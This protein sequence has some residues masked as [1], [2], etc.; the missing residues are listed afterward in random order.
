MR[1]MSILR[2]LRGM[3]PALSQPS[4]KHVTSFPRLGRTLA[5]QTQAP[6]RCI[7]NSS[8]RQII[9]PFSLAQRVSTL[10]SL[11][12]TLPLRAPHRTFTSSTRFQYPR[13]QR[14][15]NRFDGSSGAGSFFSTLIQKSKPQHF[16]VIGLGISGIYLYNTDVVEMTGRRRFNVVSH[17]QELKMGAETYREILATE[18]GK[19]LPEDHPLTRMVDRVLQRLI[20][21]APIPGANWKVHVINDPDQANAF[22]IPGGKVFV[23]TGILPI[24]QDDDGLAA[25]L[26]HE[27]A[28]VVARHPAERM[29]NSFLTVGTVFL[30]SIFFDV[31][32]HFS[33]MMMN[34]I[35]SLPNSRTQEAEADQMGLMMMSKACFNPKAAAKLWRRMQ[36]MEKRAPPQFMSTH[37]SSYNREEAIQGWMEKAQAI[38][39]D[40]GC[41]PF[42]TFSKLLPPFLVL[43]LVDGLSDPLRK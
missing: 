3:R 13:Y 33:S 25:V 31:S 16:V 8:T 26:G 30:I 22:V 38:Y 23:Y 43:C 10:R 21:E 5:P 28:H 15:Y 41:G 24:C 1:A 27:I 12:R 7:T 6:S 39:Q 40:N 29:S 4:A 34:L 17:E 36:Q 35:W 19:I 11:T 9:Q 20:P 42:K 32:G 37:P 14:S 18:R 2:A